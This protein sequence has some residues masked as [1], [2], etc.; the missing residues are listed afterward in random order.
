MTNKLEPIYLTDYKPCDF[1]VESVHLNFEL[2][3]EHTHVTTLLK[4]ARNPIAQTPNAS[5]RLHGEQLK[6][7]SVA[8]DGKLLSVSDYEVDDYFLTIKNVPDQFTLETKVEIY[9]QKNTHLMGLFK[10]RKNF[11]TQCEAEGFRFITYYFDRPDVL[12]KFTTTIIADKER[13]PYLLSNGNFIEQRDLEGGKHWIHWEDPSLKPCYLFALVAGDFDLLEDKFITCSGR[14]VKLELFIEKGFVH[15]ADYAMQSL[16]RAM[17]WDEERW[18]REYDLDIYMIVAVSDFNMGAMENKGLNVFNTKYVLAEPDTATDH[19]YVGIEGVIGHEYFHNWSGNRVTCRDWFQITLKEG[20]TVFRDQEFTS[21]MTSRAVTRLDSVGVV[22]NAQF[23][24]DGGPLAHPIRP[25]S[26]IEINNFYTLTVYRKG[27]EVIR[28]VETLITPAIFR[29]GLD[30]YF[31][32]FDGQAVTT[33]DFLSCMEEASGQ[34]L[35]QFK[36]WYSQAG[37]PTLNITSDYNESS[38]TY[39]LTVKQTCPSTPECDDKQPFYLPLSIGL[40]GDGLQETKVLTIS[41]HEE[42]FTFNNIAARPIPSLLRN[43]S[44]PVHVNYDY[45]DAELAHLLEHDSDPF[46]RWNAGQVLATR[47]I[48]N[49]C[50]QIV[51]EVTF[52]KPV[53]LVEAFTMLLDHELTDLSFLSRLL[54]LPSESYLHQHLQQVNVHHIHQAREY[55]IKV[56]AEDLYTRWAQHYEKYNDPKQP[57]TYD[58]QHVG[59]R[60]FKNVCLNYLVCS[61]NEVEYERAFTQ[62]KSA[63]NMTDRLAALFALNHSDCSQRHQAVDQFYAKWKNDP[64]V[65]NKWLT[66]Q[67]ASTLPNTFE[68]VLELMAHE[69][70]DI[71]NPNNVY[72]LLCSFGSNHVAFHDV[73][74]ETYK[75]IADQVLYLNKRNPQVAGRLLIPLTKWKNYAEPYGKLMKG[76]L[77]RISEYKDLSSD[78]YEIICKSLT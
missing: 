65:V 9:P 44:A 43:F 72:A 33:E 31:H 17:K 73:S 14:E 47:L 2:E 54:V 29:K 41:K 4:L 35:T 3:E 27:A 52:E 76:E 7:L 62:F 69:A 49:L 37:T 28:M 58:Q 40:V 77:I 34:D 59:E 24:E 51:D 15:Q 48:L 16:I 25:D 23:S 67:A 42:T 74:G 68:A 12:S 13:Y 21:D 18:G 53:L 22:R 36:H 8:L 60:S 5:L 70:F 19:D 50:Q 26:Y 55:C 66:L 78:I 75:F 61:A 38:Q 71:H 1:I 30:L 63:N 6:L 64:L 57:Y 11:C 46:A 45:T 20:L 39:Q 32:R 56:L 10:S